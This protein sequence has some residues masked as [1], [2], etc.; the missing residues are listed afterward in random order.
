M[1]DITVAAAAAATLTPHRTRSRRRRWRRRAVKS[2]VSCVYTTIKIQ[3]NKKRMEKINKKQNGRRSHQRCARNVRARQ[4]NWI[5]AARSRVGPSGVDDGVDEGNGDGEENVGV[6]GGRDG[7]EAVD[8]E[9]LRG[10]KR[11][12]K[13]ETA[14]VRALS[15]YDSAPPATAPTRHP[16]ARCPPPDARRGRSSRSPPTGL[17]R[18]STR[19]RTEPT[20]SVRIMIYVCVI[21]LLYVYTN[22]IFFPLLCTA[23]QPCYV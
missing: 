13:V 5:H 7:R 4:W 15:Y 3:K 8:A 23:A 14:G 10:P 12:P 21:L 16:F 18:A 2:R 20:G 1:C 17:P 22:P 11:Y 9:G 19:S 6:G